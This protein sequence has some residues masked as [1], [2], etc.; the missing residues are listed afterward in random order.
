M[1]QS[2]VSPIESMAT[3]LH[4]CE[5]TVMAVQQSADH[6]SGILL[7]PLTMVTLEGSTGQNEFCCRCIYCPSR[8]HRQMTKT[9]HSR[10]K[11]GRIRIL[12]EIPRRGVVKHDWDVE[13]L[14][15]GAK[16]KEIG[17]QV[18][19]IEQRAADGQ[20]LDLERG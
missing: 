9:L 3:Q 16:A 8:T 4:N 7:V 13:F 14:D 11:D 1:H 6:I 15:I 17:K 5:G 10:P 12:G 18:V 2:I 20:I 19:A